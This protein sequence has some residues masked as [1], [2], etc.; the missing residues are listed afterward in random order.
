M[1]ERPWKV[2]AL[3]VPWP[4]SIWSLVDAPSWAGG[5]TLTAVLWL[6]VGAL[7]AFVLIP[8]YVRRNGEAFCSTL[9]G[10]G[11]LA[12][13]VVLAPGG[14]REVVVREPGLVTLRIGKRTVA[15]VAEPYTK[16][17]LEL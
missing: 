13:T 11:G 10:C 5:D 4:L 8:W 7:S 14:V 1:I 15:L 2:Y 16:L 9:C 17:L 12:E 3:T 6:G